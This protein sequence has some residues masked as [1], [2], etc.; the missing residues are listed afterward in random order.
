MGGNN[1]PGLILKSP[2]PRKTNLSETG[3]LELLSEELD[4]QN[5]KQP[6]K[7]KWTDFEQQIPYP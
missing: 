4:N 3:L 6:L 1:R 5:A 7:E 2:N